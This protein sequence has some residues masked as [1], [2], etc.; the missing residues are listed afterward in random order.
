MNVTN[1]LLDR[2]A[3]LEGLKTNY[4]IAKSLGLTP[5]TVYG[6]RKGKS[7]MDDTTALMVAERLKADPMQILARLHIE[8]APT[9]RVKTVWE[10]YS[11]RLLLAV[12]G[13]ATLAT[14]AGEILLNTDY[15]QSAAVLL[16]AVTTNIH[17]THIWARA[18][19]PQGFDS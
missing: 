12:V 7:Q 2:Y 9:E 19:A 1:E 8:R 11:G 4:A 17:Y 5:P 14:L 15:T 10:K 16:S 13:T 18:A 3:E 6:Y